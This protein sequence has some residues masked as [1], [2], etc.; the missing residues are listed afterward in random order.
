VSELMRAIPVNDPSLAQVIL[1]YPGPAEGLETRADEFVRGKTLPAHF[2]LLLDPDYTFTKAYGLRWDAPGETS[3]PSTF[4]LDRN[5]KVVFAK[6]SRTH[7]GRAEAA[8]VV[9]ALRGQ[10]S[11]E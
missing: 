9:K 5:R 8:E 4:V 6:T 7:G 3:Y 11:G 2:D 1:V 10:K